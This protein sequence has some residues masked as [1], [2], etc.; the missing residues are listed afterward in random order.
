MISFIH[1]P[2]VPG[3]CPPLQHTEYSNL[4]G[5]GEAGAWLPPPV[6]GSLPQQGQM[7]R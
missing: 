2:S 6:P 7:A 3:G 1:Q 5:L 4:A